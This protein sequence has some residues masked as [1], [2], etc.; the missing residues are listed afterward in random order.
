M[1]SLGVVSETDLIDGRILP[2]P[3]ALI[4]GV[5]PREDPA[6]VWIGEGGS[7]EGAPEGTRVGTFSLRRAS[8]LDATDPDA[9]LYLGAA[10]SQLGR[11]AE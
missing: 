3:R 7:F 9:P 2:D 11:H 10:L 4:A 8:Q 6:D 5:P 1:A